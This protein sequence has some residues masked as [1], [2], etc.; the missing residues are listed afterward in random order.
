MKTKQKTCLIAVRI[1]E[2]GK[3]TGTGCR[4]VEY[5]TPWDKVISVPDSDG[6]LV[7]EYRFPDD[8][9]V[10]E[11]KSNLKYVMSD[12]DMN[13]AE[14]LILAGTSEYDENIRL[15]CAL[16]E[17]KYGPDGKLC[18]S[19]SLYPFSAKSFNHLVREYPGYDM[20]IEF[21]EDPDTRRMVMT[22]VAD[23]IED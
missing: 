10:E 23:N 16:N 19:E 6:I 17:I 3:G 15:F 12:M 21:G 4:T 13:E 7:A 14:S 5:M 9:S 22:N 8:F 2:D 20:Y 1:T 11:I 18:V